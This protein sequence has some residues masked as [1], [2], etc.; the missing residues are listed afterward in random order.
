[1]ELVHQAHE[2]PVFGIHGRDAQG[3]LLF[4]P[5]QE[6]FRFFVTWLEGGIA[7]H[8]FNLLVQGWCSNRVISTSDA[9]LSDG[10]WET[11]CGE[12]AS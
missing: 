5:L 7:R 3:Q 11:F 10:L 9:N 4:V 6:V 1:M 12:I 2:L 8:S